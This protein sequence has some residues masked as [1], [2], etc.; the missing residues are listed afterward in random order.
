VNLPGV[1]STGPMEEF[2]TH[3]GR[4]AIDVSEEDLVSYLLLG[5]GLGSCG[6]LLLRTS[7]GGHRGAYQ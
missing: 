2:R 3:Y 6:S 7:D 1:L 4:G 5:V